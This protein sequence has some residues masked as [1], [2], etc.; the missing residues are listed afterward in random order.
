M[1]LKGVQVKSETWSQCCLLACYLWRLKLFPFTISTFHSW[2]GRI[3][4]TCPPPPPVVSAGGSGTLAH[5]EQKWEA[6]LWSKGLSGLS[7]SLL[8]DYF[9]RCN[10]AG[11]LWNDSLMIRCRHFLK[12]FFFFFI[13][14]KFSDFWATLK[15]FR[16]LQTPLDM[17]SPSHQKNTWRRSM[18]VKHVDV[19]IIY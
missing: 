9:G 2:C 1:N 13:E 6:F 16:K 18:E 5:S 3:P 11:S 7:L 17:V 8:C 4:T 14:V 10:P 15:L 12:V 19:F